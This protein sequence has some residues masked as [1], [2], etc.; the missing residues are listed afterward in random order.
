LMRLMQRYL[1]SERLRCLKNGVRINVIGRR[2]RISPELVAEIENIE[3]ATAGCDRLLLRL[4]VHYSSRQAMLDA[5]KLPGHAEAFADFQRRLERVTHSVPDVQ[6]LDVLIRTG[7]ERRLSDFL[8]WE[9][10][11]A[12]LVFCDTYWPDFG[13]EEFL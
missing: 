6:P 7:G 13:E 2:D 1:V 11:Y 9:S 4:A 12:E 10:A 5:S 8:L 3:K